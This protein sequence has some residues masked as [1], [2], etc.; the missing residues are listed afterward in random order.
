MEFFLSEPMIK[1]NMEVTYMREDARNIDD[2]TVNDISEIA[3]ETKN[4]YK[5]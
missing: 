3:I 1:V 4:I 5:V 2:F